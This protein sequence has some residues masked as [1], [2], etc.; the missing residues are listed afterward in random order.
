M[1]EWMTDRKTERKKEGAHNKKYI[2]ASQ[3][4]TKERTHK[5]TTHKKDITK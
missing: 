2:T 4:I 1:N 5:R 3:N